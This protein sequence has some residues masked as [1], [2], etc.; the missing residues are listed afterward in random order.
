MQLLFERMLAAEFVRQER[1][2][3]EKSMKTMPQTKTEGSQEK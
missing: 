2:V 1:H 3:T